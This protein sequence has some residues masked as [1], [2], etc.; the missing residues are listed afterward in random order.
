VVHGVKP[1]AGRT[2]QMGGR[3]S[4]ERSGS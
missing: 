1:G 3:G 2:K 4:G